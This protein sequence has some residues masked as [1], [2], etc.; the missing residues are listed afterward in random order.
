MSNRFPRWFILGHLETRQCELASAMLTAAK[1]EDSGCPLSPSAVS[2]LLS[3]T[4][5]LSFLLLHR[6]SV[7]LE[8]FLDGPGSAP[9]ARDTQ[10]SSKSRAL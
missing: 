7:F 6:I 4:P 8:H 3:V 9:G 2:F 10:H 5:P 1:G